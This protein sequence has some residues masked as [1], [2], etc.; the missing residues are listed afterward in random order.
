MRVNNYLETFIQN[1]GP[2]SFFRYEKVIRHA[3]FFFI[4]NGETT[5]CETSLNKQIAFANHIKIA[6]TSK[7]LSVV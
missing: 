4:T 6:F 2:V 3:D 1:N 5:E 7:S